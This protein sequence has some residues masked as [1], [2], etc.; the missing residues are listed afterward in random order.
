MFSCICWET[1]PVLTLSLTEAHSWGKAREADIAG[2]L[3]FLECSCDSHAQS[4]VVSPGRHSLPWLHG[5]ATQRA[6][7]TWPW[8][9]FPSQIPTAMGWSGA[10]GLSFLLPRE[11]T[12]CF[13]F[14][15]LFFFSVWWT[16]CFETS[17]HSILRHYLLRAFVG[18]Q[19]CEKDVM[20]MAWVGVE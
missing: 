18:V 5:K 10:L 8:L 17:N 19:S 2:V 12:T 1:Q 20:G 9:G 13:L 7:Y 3:A 6:L 4:S 14:S 11:E 16:F 15:F